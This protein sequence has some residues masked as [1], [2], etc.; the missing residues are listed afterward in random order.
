MSMKVTRLYTHW[1]PAEA[2][3]IIEFLELL[4]DQLWDTYGDQI[5]SLLHEASVS[6]D[7]DEHQAGIE[8]NDDIEF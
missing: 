2:Q 4:R 1:S 8:F 7:V 3:I 6:Q 5:I